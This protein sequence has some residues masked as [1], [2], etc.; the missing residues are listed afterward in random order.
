MELDTGMVQEMAEQWSRSAGETYPCPADDKNSK[1][2]RC[3]ASTILSLSNVGEPPT[4][5]LMASSIQSHL[6]PRRQEEI[7][8]TLRIYILYGMV[9]EERFTF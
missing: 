5:G 9:V 8:L 6:N 3:N 1:R 7:Y 2:R 4:T